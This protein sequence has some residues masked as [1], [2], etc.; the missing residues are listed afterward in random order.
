MRKENTKTRRA[1]YGKSERQV[2]NAHTTKEYERERD[3]P[4]LLAVWPCELADQ[5]R[6]GTFYLIGKLKNALRAERHRGRSGHWSYDLGRHIGLVNA[7]KAETSAYSDDM[8]S[9]P[10]STVPRSQTTTLS[11]KRGKLR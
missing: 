1:F 11:H 3:L 7:L 10:G 9:K 5:S 4:R 8:E 2:S 6:S